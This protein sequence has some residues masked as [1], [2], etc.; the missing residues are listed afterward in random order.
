MERLQV[1]EDVVDSSENGAC[2]THEQ[3]FCASAFSWTVAR[4]VLAET[5][6]SL[7]SCRPDQNACVDMD[8]AFAQLLW[9]G[10]GQ[11]EASLPV[12]SAFLARGSRDNSRIEGF[13]EGNV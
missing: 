7:N 11:T 5:W 12:Y 8:E 13:P 9:Q 10:H 3:D 4:N 2:G 6:T 1:G